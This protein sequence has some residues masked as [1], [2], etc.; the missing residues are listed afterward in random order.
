MH[1]LFQS[2]L[3]CFFTGLALYPILALGQSDLT[4]YNW[5]GPPDTIYS[6]NAFP[7][8]GI[9]VAHEQLILKVVKDN[10]P[11][12]QHYGQRILYANT[13]LF[14]HRI[15]I[16]RTQEAI[17]EFK[18]EPLYNAH[19]GELMAIDARISRAGHG[20]VDL[21]HTQLD[22]R[23]EMDPI[24]QEITHT[25][26]F[27]KL[28][29]RPGDILETIVAFGFQG[30]AQ[31]RELVIPGVY[32]IAEKEVFI[33]SPFDIPI[34]VETFNGFPP[35]VIDSSSTQV[36]RKWTFNDLDPL[37]GNPI[38]L[39]KMSAPFLS[40]YSEQA[41]N[42]S[43]RNDFDSNYPYVRYSGKYSQALTNW[44]ERLRAS[45]MRNA[46]NVDLFRHFV[47]FVN[48]SVQ[49]EE[50]SVV[51]DE[52]PIGAYFHDRHMSRQKLIAL[53]RHLFLI[54]E[55]DLYLCYTRSKYQGS[56]HR[57]TLYPRE[58]TA[59]VLALKDRA[60]G[61]MHW[62]IPKSVN[63]SFYLDELPAEIQGQPAVLFRFGEDDK[64]DGEL[65]QITLPEISATNN[66][67]GEQISVS[68]NAGY[69]RA[70]LRI[71]GNLS[72]CIATA[73]IHG[74]TTEIEQRGHPSSVGASNLVFHRYSP[75]VHLN[76][77]SV[78]FMKAT[79][80]VAEEID[81]S[82]MVTRSVDTV[83]VD[84]S[85]ILTAS[86]YQTPLE[87]SEYCPILLPFP[88][89]ERRDLFL[90]FPT[91]VQLFGAAMEP[92]EFSNVIG[93]IRVV[94]EKINDQTIALHYELVIRN[95]WVDGSLYPML[96]A[97]RTSVL[98]AKWK[99]ITVL[100]LN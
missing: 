12:H 36:V 48:D 75:E 46:S 29:L 100:S 4:E 81:M 80:S 56:I 83:C 71:R 18:R 50:E 66:S 95:T 67:I 84:I 28:D 22:H 32:P 11:Q 2:I 6:P 78:P 74:D 5:P 70:D 99:M 15:L 72:G 90:Q 45:S 60:T 33:S 16:F 27:S 53:Y 79:Y 97:L 92:W 73:C 1:F 64:L 82:R 24:S 69:S 57:D 17:N 35:L 10:G 55:D 21:L 40:T 37:P 94:S 39:S 34:R 93:N 76:I 7:N 86:F 61:N 38:C 44:V 62:S 9:L 8:S 96:N 51:N 19:D 87:W 14:Y 54:L 25:I 23:S 47:A 52:R 41:F 59:M 77:D 68:I 58:T 89:H 88:Y 98:D 43:R 65:Q 3:R 26:G 42:G 31:L 85:S 20:V 30:L 13:S 91:S 63:A 49:I